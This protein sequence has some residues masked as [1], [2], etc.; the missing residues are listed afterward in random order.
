MPKVSPYINFAGK[1]AEALEFYKNVFGGETNIQFAKDGPNAA[2]TS[3]DKLEQ[4]FHADLNA[5]SFHILAS[6]MMSSGE[7]PVNNII[8]LALMCDSEAQLRNYFEKLNQ[9]GK[10]V[11]PV[12]DS[13]WGSIYA[14]VV[15]RYGI[16]WMLNF[17]KSGS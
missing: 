13:E 12:R 7:Q 11:W 5:G 4:V 3:A 1:T 2:K 6:D 10:V 8:S 15:D 17:D 14:Q 16:Q 9:G